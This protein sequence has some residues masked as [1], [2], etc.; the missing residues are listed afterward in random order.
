METATKLSIYLLP[1]VLGGWEEGARG[2]SEIPCPLHLYRISE[3]KENGSNAVTKACPESPDDSHI[4]WD[5]FTWGIKREMKK[6]K[7]K[8]NNAPEKKRTEHLGR[9]PVIKRPRKKL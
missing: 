5:V 6:Q 1:R 3:R 4:C 2:W 7:W 8:I 9:E